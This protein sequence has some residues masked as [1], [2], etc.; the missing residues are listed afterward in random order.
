MYVVPE[1]LDMQRG[2]EVRP[3]ICAGHL[4]G[5]T[6]R[7]PAMRTGIKQKLCKPRPKYAWLW[8]AHPFTHRGPG[9][10]HSVLLERVV[11]GREM[12]QWSQLSLH[13]EDT[14]PP[15]I[16]TPSPPPLDADI[17]TLPCAD[18]CTLHVKL[19]VLP[20]LA[21]RSRHLISCDNK[22]TQYLDF[23]GEDAFYTHACTHTHKY[24]P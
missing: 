22:H 6:T 19:T 9:R 2:S 8:G 5:H 24:I 11:A 18:F 16:T 12:M 21:P 13:R 3:S 15:P 7:L 23:K 1:M 17:S 20:W 10:N 14:P 4:D